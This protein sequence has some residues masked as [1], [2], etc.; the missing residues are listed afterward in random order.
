MSES[1]RRLVVIILKLSVLGLACWIISLNVSWLDAVEL[2][3]GT[4]IQGEIIEGSAPVL[5]K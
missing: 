5:P 1:N 2:I 3:D 4:V